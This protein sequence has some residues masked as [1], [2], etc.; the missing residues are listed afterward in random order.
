VQ[1]YAEISV[2]SQRADEGYITPERTPAFGKSLLGRST[3]WRIIDEGS[4]IKNM[5][6]VY[7]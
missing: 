7:A 5:G 1:R 4:A 6:T 2:S 3:T